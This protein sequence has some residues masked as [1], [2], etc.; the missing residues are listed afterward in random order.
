MRDNVVFIPVGSSCPLLP[1][2]ILGDA[3]YVEGI[4]PRKKA[5]NILPAFTR[6]SSQIIQNAQGRLFTFSSFLQSSLLV[7]SCGSVPPGSPHPVPAAAAPVP[8]VSAPT[9]VT[10]SVLGR[11]FTYITRGSPAFFTCGSHTH[12]NTLFIFNDDPIS[13]VYRVF[14]GQ[15]FGT[16]FFFR[17]KHVRNAL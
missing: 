6:V 1:M 7:P 11:L 2:D 13:Y 17:R 14:C 3:A 12:V 4:C 8:S 9:C 5:F 10:A 15:M 16:F